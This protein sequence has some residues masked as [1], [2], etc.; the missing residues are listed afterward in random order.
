MTPISPGAYK[1]KRQD[2]TSKILHAL[3]DVVSSEGVV[4]FSV[5]AV[6]D[7]AQ[8]SHRTVYRHYPSREALLEGLSNYVEDPMREHALPDPQPANLEGLLAS[9]EPTF[10]FFE[11][12]APMIEAM[13]VVRMALGVEPT[14]SQERTQ[15]FI[16]VV[17][18]EAPNLTAADVRKYGIGLRS[19]AS[20]EHWYSL[21]RRLGLDAESASSVTSETIRA[22]VGEIRRR[23]A[24]QGR[25]G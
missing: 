20:S 23:N 2:T 14:R 13:V 24:R 5:Q 18:Q 9:I 16:D 8:V 7:R 11:N 19:I 12:Y 1:T 25:N 10:E 21:R 4:A 3:V 6:A 17:R 15:E 22:L